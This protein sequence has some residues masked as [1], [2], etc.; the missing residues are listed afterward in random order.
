MDIT[1]DKDGL[2]AGFKYKQ[3]IHG[4]AITPLHKNVMVE[5]MFFGIQT[6]GKGLILPNDDGLDRGIK[7][8]WAQ[9][10]AVGPEQKDVKVGDYVLIEHGRWTRG[11]E[12]T[13]TDGNEKTIR[14]VDVNAIL[15]TSD[16]EMENV[17]FGTKTDAGDTKQA[18]PEDFGAN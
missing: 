15:A 8:R 7:P 18:R 1:K 12:L 4:N 11:Y 3:V 17:I 16:T 10:H 9:V 5:E 14:M 6:T 2:G 13:D